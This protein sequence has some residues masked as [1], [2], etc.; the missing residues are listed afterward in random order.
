MIS[1]IKLKKIEALIERQKRLPYVFLR[2]EE[3]VDRFFYYIENHQGRKLE[4]V[5]AKRME[6]Y[7]RK[8]N[9][10]KT[11]NVCIQKKIFKKIHLT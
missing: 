9:K 2:T 6:E 8:L 10:H 5:L 4:G 1:K 7:V 11:D 3:E